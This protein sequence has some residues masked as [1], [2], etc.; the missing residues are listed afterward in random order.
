MDAIRLQDSWL[1]QMS[2]VITLMAIFLPVAA[3]A[4]KYSHV[5]DSIRGSS[6]DR[7]V[8]GQLCCSHQ[9]N[10]EAGLAPGATLQMGVP[11]P[12]KSSYSRGRGR[13][14]MGNPKISLLKDLTGKT[15][16]W[17]FQCPKYVT[18]KA[19]NAYTLPFPS[20]WLLFLRFNWSSP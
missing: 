6:L 1:A 7:D 14:K 4:P 10:K 8:Q 17:L 15:G 5:W 3:W 13:Y 16:L 12:Q 2:A 20:H 11:H 9:T 18:P 19:S